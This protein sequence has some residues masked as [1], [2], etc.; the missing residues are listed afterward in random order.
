MATASHPAVEFMEVTSP[1]HIEQA[2]ELF[3][4][5]ASSLGF[6]LCFQ[7]FDAEVRTLPGAYAAPSGRLFLAFSGGE[8]AGCIGLR[9]LEPSI[10]EMKRLY[11]RPAFRGMGI[12]MMLVERLIAEA[13]S[14]GYERMR[15]D[16]VAASMQ[17]AVALYRR[18]GFRDIAPYRSNPLAGV[19]YLELAL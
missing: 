18:R 5:Y 9:P 3:L 13:R 16:T 11:V 12:G 8:V 2:R 14:I 19:I 10:C 15:L 17:L 1:E 6:S 7:N 4:E